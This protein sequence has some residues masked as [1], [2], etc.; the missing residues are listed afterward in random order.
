MSFPHEGES[1]K[2]LLVDKARTHT[3]DDQERE[4]LIGFCAAFHDCQAIYNKALAEFKPGSANR[5]NAWEIKE[6]GEKMLR[7]LR[8]SNL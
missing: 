8:P 4:D 2:A 3:M 7:Q 1:Y 5:K 6:K